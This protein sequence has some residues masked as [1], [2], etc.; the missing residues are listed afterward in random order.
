LRLKIINSC[1]DL[2]MILHKP[3][4]EVPWEILF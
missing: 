3:S 4:G 2:A 1:T